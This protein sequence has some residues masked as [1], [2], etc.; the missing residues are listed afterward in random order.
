MPNEGLFRLT[1]AQITF[2]RFFLCNNREIVILKISPKTYLELIPSHLL[3][4]ETP[5][6]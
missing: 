1:P 4:L 5:P 3:L 6:G 2:P